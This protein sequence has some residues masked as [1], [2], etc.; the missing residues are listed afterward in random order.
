ML[1]FCIGAC[2]CGQY[3]SV[4]PFLFYQDQYQCSSIP[5]GFISCLEYV[6]SLPAGNR[7]NYLPT[8]SMYT[9]ANKFGDYRCSDV[10][11]TINTSILIMFIGTIIAYL[12]MSILGGYFGRKTFMIIGAFSSIIGTLVAVVASSI[13][14]ASVGLL[15]GSFGG[16]IL[17]N[18]GFTIIS[19][20]VI[21]EKRETCL[22]IFQVFYSFGHLSNTAFYFFI[23]DWEKVFIISYIIPAT[24]FIICYIIIA[25]DTPL[26]LIKNL[27]P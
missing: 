7:A 14:F 27:S 22:V 10:A 19:E 9:L 12:F 6:C 1:L 8:P 11:S 15:I 23:R 21:E 5:S 20:I 2:I 16:Q 25:V 26:A 4:T 17:F 3:T 18:I 24:I 13:Y